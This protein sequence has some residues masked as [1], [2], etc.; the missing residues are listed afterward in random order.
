[1]K[2]ELK[3]NVCTYL[4]SRAYV[5]A[6]VRVFLCIHMQ[7][8]CK[9]SLIFHATI[10]GRNEENKVQEVKTKRRSHGG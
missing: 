6:R 4:C 10:H 3:K 9:E 2:T 1:M 5:C 7:C 8:V